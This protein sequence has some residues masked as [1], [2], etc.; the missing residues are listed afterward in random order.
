M[1]DSSLARANSSFVSHACK[2]GLDPTDADSAR[3][4]WEGQGF[5][6]L[7][8][9]PSGFCSPA[10]SQILR[11]PLP[12]GYGAHPIDSEGAL[13]SPDAPPGLAPFGWGGPLVASWG[14][15]CHC[16]SLQKC[17]NPG[18][19]QATGRHR[20]FTHLPA[21]RQ[22]L[23]GITLTEVRRCMNRKTHPPPWLETTWLESS[24]RYG[25]SSQRSPSATAPLSRNTVGC[26][27][28][29]STTTV[30]SQRRLGSRSEVPND[31]NTGAI[32]EPVDI[33]A[34]LTRAAARVSLARQR[35]WD[36]FGRRR[37]N[38]RSDGRV[39]T[40]GAPVRRLGG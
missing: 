12:E 36:P 39:P 38:V 26:S 34:I 21:R 18:H 11:A 30:R 29:S 23:T 22:V 14:S 3:V 33:A 8:R 19:R 37:V 6:S 17:S 25:P 28:E 27:L 20:I 13:V 24:R 5:D 4:R 10:N 7:V 35:D 2:P 9:Y 31:R 32:A 1:P 40:T 16:G 15:R